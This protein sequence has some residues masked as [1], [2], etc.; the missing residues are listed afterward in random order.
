L[1]EQQVSR[2]SLISSTIEPRALLQEELK[3]LQEYSR[4]QQQQQQAVPPLPVAQD[5]FPSYAPSQG[6]SLG[7]PSLPQYPHQQ[8][9]QSSYFMAATPSTYSAMPSVPIPHQQQH[10]QS[11]PPAMA[12]MAVSQSVPG[13]YA[14]HAQAGYAYNPSPGLGLPLQHPLPSSAIHF[15]QMPYGATQVYQ[16]QQQHQHQHQQPFE[17]GQGPPPMHNTNLDSGG[18]PPQ[19]LN[20]PMQN[21]YSQ[22]PSMPPPPPPPIPPRFP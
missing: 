11:L 6:T 18:Y 14:Q 10:Q 17:A 15:S 13:G 21:N 22:M 19:H 12:A 2:P 20:Y 3:R 9:H 5:P 7:M 8:P 16:Q 4:Q 1:A